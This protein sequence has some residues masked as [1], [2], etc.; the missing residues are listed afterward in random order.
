MSQFTKREVPRAAQSTVLLGVGTGGTPT[1]AIA[2]LG[3]GLVPSLRSAAGFVA[4]EH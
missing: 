1:R 3:L 2:A 4:L